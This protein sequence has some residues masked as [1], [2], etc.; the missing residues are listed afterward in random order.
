MESHWEG[1]SKSTV[2]G[3][4]NDLLGTFE[5]SP[6]LHARATVLAPLLSKVWDF[7]E[8]A[9]VF[10]LQELTCPRLKRLDLVTAS[11]SIEV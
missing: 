5:L 7:P 4:Q 10:A 1:K 8:L 11:K 3:E 6:S 2:T 9:P